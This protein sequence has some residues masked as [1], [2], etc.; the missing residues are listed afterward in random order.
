MQFFI[1]LNI[2]MI[3]LNFII[4]TLT[5]LLNYH[6]R[7]RGSFKSGIHDQTTGDMLRTPS[8]LDLSGHHARPDCRP[9][10]MHSNRKGCRMNRQPA[11]AALESLST[12]RPH[13]DKPGLSHSYHNQP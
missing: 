12:N 10:Q 5:I 3:F 7:Y 11:T 1:S 4:D 13:P 6:G 8:R 2:K 9:R